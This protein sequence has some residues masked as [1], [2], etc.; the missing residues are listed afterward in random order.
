MDNKVKIAA[1]VAG[2]TGFALSLWA[3]KKQVVTYK[4]APVGWIRDK[5]NLGRRFRNWFVTLAGWE[6]LTDNTISLT[7]PN[8]VPRSPLPLSMFGT[9]I[10]VTKHA[11][12][13][14][15]GGYGFLVWDLNKKQIMLSKDGSLAGAW[16]ILKGPPEELLEAFRQLDSETDK[17]IAEIETHNEEIKEKG[18]LAAMTDEEIEDLKV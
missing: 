1:S 5:R 8:G 12:H 16:F 2:V 13:I 14:K 3:H 15:C 11:F 6:S 17:K 9:R 18:E 7:L 10:V 4:Q